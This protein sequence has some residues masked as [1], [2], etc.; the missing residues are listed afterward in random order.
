LTAVSSLAGLCSP[1]GVANVT[2]VSR[3]SAASDLILEW[4]PT[5]PID[6]VGVL[7]GAMLVLLVIAWA[8]S[9]PVPP[10]EVI[11]ILAISGFALIAVRNVVPA[12]LLV[13]PVV[14]ARLAAAFP[15][16]GRAPEPRWS[17]P[18][19]VVLAGILTL[20]AIATLPSREHLPVERHPISL[21]RHL[22]ALPPGQRV[23]N[24]YNTAGLVLWF[25]GV[26]T[27]VGIDGRTDRYGA[28]YI[29]D[30]LDLLAARGE[31]QELLTRLD[32]TSALIQEDSALAH[33]L[34][35]ERGWR[36]FKR[37]SGFV[38]LIAPHTDDGR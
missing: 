23:L 26:T 11:A 4:Q 18:A 36:V 22:S 32:P 21:A 8:R 25:G 27:R 13:A 1:A 19:G 29:R 10:G 33:I 6:D 20:V 38:L 34:T 14:A 15:T 3:L 7:I 31:W 17:A 5:S 30:Y 16:V 28:E 24:H 35:A 2:A 12:L 9:A 37:E